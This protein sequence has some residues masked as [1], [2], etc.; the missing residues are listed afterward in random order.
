MVVKSDVP[1]MAKKKSY[2]QLR[3][4]RALGLKNDKSDRH[5]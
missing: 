5:L 1:R 4:R 2:V 3:S